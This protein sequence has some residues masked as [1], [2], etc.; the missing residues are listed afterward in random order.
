MDHLVNGIEDHLTWVQQTHKSG[1]AV[2]YLR[3]FLEQFWLEV[4]LALCSSTTSNQCCN[5]RLKIVPSGD[6]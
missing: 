6:A 5:L 4:S 2:S 3:A 1:N